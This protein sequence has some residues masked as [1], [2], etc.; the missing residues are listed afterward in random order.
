MSL[1][2]EL[3]SLYA[4]HPHPIAPHLGAA[5]VSPTPDTLRVMTL[6]LN[7]YISAPDWP[8][9]PGWFPEWFREQRHQ[10]QKSVV[11]E[12]ARLSQHL[13]G[14]RGAFEG[15]RFAGLESSFHTNAVK[16]YLREEEGKRAAQLGR[17]LLD[18]HAAGFRAE[19]ELLAEHG[20]LPHVIA[21]FGAPFWS[22]AWGALKSLTNV[23]ILRHEFFPGPMLDFVNRYRVQVGAHEQ[24]LV[25]LRLRHPAARTSEGSLDALL[26]DP[27][28]RLA[29]GRDVSCPGV[30]QADVCR[31]MAGFDGTDV[32]AG[33]TQQG[34]F[35]HTE[36]G[37][38]ASSRGEADTIEPSVVSHLETY[39]DRDAWR[40]ALLSNTRLAAGHS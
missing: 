26:A 15:L 9:V 35:I 14:A 2:D 20:A 19:L 6:G 38:P 10:H 13:T 31:R 32:V 1:P 29:T 12:T 7:A 27:E 39:P 40:A 33:T 17:E 22:H 4:R 5:F 3:Q 36:G 24:E 16:S 8:P 11:R 37:E 34:F 30:P 23:R 28:F 25:L 21:I 18:Q